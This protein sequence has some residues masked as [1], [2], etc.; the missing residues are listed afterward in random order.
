ME[1]IV[2]KYIFDQFDKSKI[3]FI[4]A[5]G[6][7]KGSDYDIYCVVDD[8]IE[9]RVQIF[10]DGN[11]WIELF[12]DNWSDMKNKLANSD[13]I[14][15]SFITNMPNIFD[16][17]SLESAKMSIP[18]KF[19]LPQKR[20]N[21]IYYRIKVLYSKYNGVATEN[22]K[23]YFKGLILPHLFMLAFDHG[24][25]WPASPKQWFTQISGMN[26][27]FAQ[28]VLAAQHNTTLFEEICTDAE[29]KCIGISIVKKSS[30]N[31]MTFLG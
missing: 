11:D 23:Q 9:S 2:Q 14:C 20:I 26:D 31:Q 22:E 1:H 28:K 6:L 30:D 5:Q 18:E 3:K 27:T 4:N 25:I 7:E 8:S 13:E 15:A 10:K 29:N 17:H 19:K 12:I 21:L 16:T 24:G